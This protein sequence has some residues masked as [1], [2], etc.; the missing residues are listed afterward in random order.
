[1]IKIYEEAAR[2][3]R[4]GVPCAVLTIIESKGS[5]PQKEGAKMLVR[6]DGTTLGTIGGGC[7]EAEAVQA[8]VMAIRDARPT[9]LPFELKEEHGGLVC[10]GSL[11]V[12]IEPVVPAPR[13]IILG[14]GHVG[15]ALSKAAKFSG[16]HVAVFDNREEY[17][18]LD[19]MPDADEVVVAEFD[20][21]FADGRG[22][23]APYV[24][25]A[26]RG[27]NHD[28]D[29]VRSSLKSRARYI[30]LLGSRRKK[31]LLFKRL[32]EEGFSDIDIKRVSIPV[33]LPIGSVTPEEIAISIM[34]EIIKV[35]RTDGASRFGG[36]ACG[37][38]VEQ[39]GAAEAA[40]AATG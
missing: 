8:A 23:G 34:A 17:A 2:L 3:G 30:G 25:V 19:S 38:Q 33:G 9:T 36:G 10:G 15:R 20:G 14:A 4:E 26:T 18:S 6:E 21:L 16:F 40:P 27:H 12:Y 1:M 29:A 24:V 35:R 11:K 13:L 7:M 39:D 5:S 31:A 32:K 37:G 22:E 28:L